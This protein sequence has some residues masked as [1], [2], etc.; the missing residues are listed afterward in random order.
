MTREVTKT[1]TVAEAPKKAE[2]AAPQPTR[3]A[4]APSKSAPAESGSA[5]VT[6]ADVVLSV[7]I[8]TSWG[9][10]AIGED[11]EGM[12]SSWSEFA[13][14]SV[15]AS[16][17]A[18]PSLGS[19]SNAPGVPGVYAV[20]S[21]GLARRY[22]NEDLVATDPNDLSGVCEP[23]A[24]R[25]FERAPYSGLVQEWGSCGD[26][27]GGYL[28]LAATPRGEECVVLL[29]VG[30][31]GQEGAEAGQHA[32]DTFGVDCGAAA[33]SPPASAD[34][35]YAPEQ[36][37][38]DSEPTPTPRQEVDCSGFTTMSG[39]PSQWQA[40]QFYDFVA[41]PEQRAILD[42]DGDGFACDGSFSEP[43]RTQYEP[44]TPEPEVS[45]PPPGD[46][47]RVPPPTG[48]Y[49]SPEPGPQIP[50]YE[51]TDEPP[52]PSEPPSSSAPPPLPDP[53]GD[54]TCDEIG[55]TDIPVPPGSKHDGD[56]DGV[57]C[58]S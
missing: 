57:A 6:V 31:V 25:A 36:D 58:E 3:A 30:T 29:Q 34:E 54:W 9:E 52:A 8:P 23:G 26:A 37:A 45:E 2:A 55:Q 39:E 19:W 16:I 43:E 1:V 33:S 28:T 13:G 41:T 46:E 27:V 32:L 56:D 48:Q 21:E 17:T 47:E 10:I 35:Q 51:K 14:E 18:A 22:A 40:Q 5:Y 20:A 12:G 49:G 38:E 4:P 50:G 11:S 15:E 7:E 53:Y 44:E 24:Q 42:P